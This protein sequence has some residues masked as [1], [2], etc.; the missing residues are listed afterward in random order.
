MLTSVL[1]L[2]FITILLKE[3][4]LR[5]PYEQQRIAY[6]SRL[7]E[8]HFT[9]YHEVDSAKIQSRL[10]PAQPILHSPRN[11]RLH[12]LQESAYFATHVRP[13]RQTNQRRRLLSKRGIRAIQY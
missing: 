9:S 10:L 3:E 7:W 6:Y 12:R 11:Q 2:I 1:P 4:P 5:S 13:A 8:V